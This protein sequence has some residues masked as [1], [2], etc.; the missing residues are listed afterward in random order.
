MPLTVLT[1]APYSTTALTSTTS[2]EIVTGTPPYL[3]LILT[4]CSRLLSTSSTLYIRL[5]DIFGLV[6]VS[7]VVNPYVVEFIF[8]HRVVEPGA[9]AVS[10]RFLVNCS[11][12]IELLPSLLYREA[13]TTSGEEDAVQY[14]FKLFSAERAARGR[15]LLC[16]TASFLK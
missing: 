9:S 1:S 5:T 4:L 11:V 3:Q 6:R 12:P 2:K 16:G 8:S 10:V 13:P 7:T 15:S 14:I